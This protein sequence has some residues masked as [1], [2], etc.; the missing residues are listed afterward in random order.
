MLSFLGRRAS[1]EALSCA[2]GRNK[3]GSYH[4]RQRELRVDPFARAQKGDIDAAADAVY[5]TLGLE[6]PPRTA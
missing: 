3:E 5:E 6:R 2:T 1:D 4:R